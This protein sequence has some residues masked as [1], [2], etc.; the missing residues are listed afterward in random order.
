VAGLF[1]WSGRKADAE[2]VAPPPPRT[3][4]AP[5]RNTK[6]LPRFLAAL[7]PIDSPVL[8]NLGPVVGQ[9]IAFFGERLG[10]KIFVEDIVAEL[11]EAPRAADEIK[12]VLEKRLPHKPGSIDGILCW[13]LFDLLDRP[14]S[15]ALAGYLA[16]LLKPGGVL[17]AFFGATAAPISHHTRYIVAAPDSFELRTSPAPPKPRNVLVTRDINKMFEGLVVTESVLLKSNTRE[18]LFRKPS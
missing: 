16:R 9:N 15:Q 12:A 4:S 2:T 18:T 10:C 13:D 1:N 14:T 3:S 6:V 5:E 11:A 17:Y 7:A 8:I